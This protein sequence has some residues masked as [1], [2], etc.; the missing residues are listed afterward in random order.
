MAA[1]GVLPIWEVDQGAAVA[2]ESCDIGKGGRRLDLGV[3]G[4]HRGIG[5]IREIGAPDVVVDFGEDLIAVAIVILGGEG[6]GGSASRVPAGDG[7]SG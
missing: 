3:G 6:L 2:E 7:P 1:R 5:V 4:C